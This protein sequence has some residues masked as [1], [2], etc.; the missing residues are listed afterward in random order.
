MK[1]A[2]PIEVQ[3][4]GKQGFKS[5]SMAA[6][7]ARRQTRA[8]DNPIGFYRCPH[9]HDWHV[10]GAIPRAGKYAGKND[11]TVGMPI[12]RKHS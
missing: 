11:K 10:G 1:F 7:V 5:Q 3:C 2:L 4:L 8:K 12:L 6:R 9:C